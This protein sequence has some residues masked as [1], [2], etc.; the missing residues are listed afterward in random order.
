MNSTGPKAETRWSV[1]IKM[2]E[3]LPWKT[4]DTWPGRRSG[5]MIV[6]TVILSALCGVVT[7]GFLSTVCYE[8][9]KL[10]RNGPP[11]D[12]EQ[13][14]R[15]EPFQ[16]SRYDTHHIPPA[17]PVPPPPPVADMPGPQHI[18]TAS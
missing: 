9:F 15:P 17:P 3:A 4:V 10:W 8:C 14:Q 7:I 2:N 12:Q 6:I 11:E 16:A 1:P 5:D 18:S 13:Q